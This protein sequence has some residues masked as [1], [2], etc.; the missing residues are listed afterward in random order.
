MTILKLAIFASHNGST[1]QSVIDACTDGR[2]AAVPT[3]VISNN[4]KSVALQRVTEAGI[5]GYLVNSKTHPDEEVR[6]GYILHLLQESQVDLIV[7]AGY[8]KK[9]GPKTLEA[10]AGRI[11][12]T[13]PALLPKFGGKGMYGMFVH[14]AVLAAGE[15]ETGVTIHIVDE[16]YDH[17]PI[18]A[19]KRVPVHRGDTPENLQDRVMEAEKELY[20]DTIKGMIDGTLIIPKPRFASK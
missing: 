5:R 4:S 3:L 19:Q 18:I 13:H 15:H 8:M 20:V 2:L 14:E 6:D 10:F 11:L 12:N 7:L 9:I 17:G 16:E 1:M